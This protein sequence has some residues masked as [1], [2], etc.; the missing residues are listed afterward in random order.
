MK[1]LAE[2]R[3]NLFSN[4]QRKLRGEDPDVYRYDELPNEL[5]VQIVQIW[6]ST[7][8]D[9]NF[10]VEH[11]SSNVY[12]QI[13]QVLRHELGVFQLP[14]DDSY[15]VNPLMEIVNYFLQLEDVEKAL[16]V[17]QVAFAIMGVYKRELLSQERHAGTNSASTAIENLNFRFKK[18]GVGYQFEHPHIFRVDSEFIHSEIVKPALGLLNEKHLSG[19]REEFLK[20][21]EFY[22]RGESKDAI[23]NCLK[24]FESTM[25]A[26][27]KKRKWECGSKP[28]AKT[29]I[30]TCL[31]N[32]LVP[33]Y[34]QQ[35]YF[36]LEVI[37]KSGIP[38]ARNNLSV[39]HGQGGSV[40]TVPDYLVA[41][42]MHMTASAIV[43]LAEAD[44]GMK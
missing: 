35:Q 41:Y 28:I 30:Q 6:T 36:S 2:L 15:P 27:C 14:S 24:S 40:V 22:R 3:G 7:F 29:L 17:V 23:A 20:A 44:K 4:R 8:G 11:P 9:Q 33:Q 26:I 1:Y 13:A 42:V 18:H 10:R 25:K 38:P 37:L 43:F 39:G 34:W 21:H 32:G 19:A 12:E 5:R 16:D 31:K